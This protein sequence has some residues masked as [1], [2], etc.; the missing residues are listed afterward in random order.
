MVDPFTCPICNSKKCVPAAGSK[1]SPI[2]VIGEMPG[3]DE[4]IK[5]RP[6]V[7]RMG[8]VL[9]MELGKLGMDL[10]RLRL[11]N[12]WHHKPNNNED[13]YRHGFEQVIKE[14]KGRK[15]ILL[16][17]SE[18]VKAFCNESVSKVCGLQVKSPYLSAPI[19]YACVN[20]AQVFH[21][22]IGELRLAIKKFV[23]VTG[24]LL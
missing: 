17:G 9:K 23:E 24:E 13:C 16:L 18:S 3:K 21:G 8:E 15:A 4:L 1:N 7:G 5:G 20:P 19:I 12:L 2:L 6:M 14:A 11:C 10:N 22:T